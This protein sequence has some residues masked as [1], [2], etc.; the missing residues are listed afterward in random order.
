V[1]A[2]LWLGVLLIVLPTAAVLL[3]PEVRNLRSRPHAS[4]RVVERVA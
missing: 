3:V 4:V 1:D 2:T